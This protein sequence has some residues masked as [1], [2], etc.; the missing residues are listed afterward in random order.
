VKACTR[1]Q[2]AGDA[3]IDGHPPGRRLG[4]VSV[5]GKG[6]C[7]K[8]PQPREQSRNLIAALNIA[9]PAALPDRKINVDTRKKLTGRKLKY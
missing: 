3:A 5:K 6:S 1:L 2:Q 9:M 7:L 8:I 4:K